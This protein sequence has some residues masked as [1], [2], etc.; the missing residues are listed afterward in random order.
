[1]LRVVG[2]RLRACVRE[3]DTVA[4]LGGDEFVLV[5]PGKP[6]GPAFEADVTALMHKL[7]AR[8]EQVC[9]MIDAGPSLRAAEGLIGSAFAAYLLQ[10]RVVGAPLTCGRHFDFFKAR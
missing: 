7:S 2:A 10:K 1:M 4:R 3:S 5:V 6:A 8:A 9:D